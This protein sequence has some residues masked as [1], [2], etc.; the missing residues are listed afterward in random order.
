MERLR[1][2]LSPGIRTLRAVTAR[3]SLSPSSGLG[4]ESSN[5]G[6]ESPLPLPLPRLCPF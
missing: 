5:R 2:R 4:V 1:L 3:S 6:I